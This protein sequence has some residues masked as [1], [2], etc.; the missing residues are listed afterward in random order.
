MATPAEV[1]QSEIPAEESSITREQRKALLDAF[2]QERDRTVE[3]HQQELDS[4]GAQHLQQRKEMMDSLDLRREAWGKENGKLPDRARESA[5]ALE[6][7]RQKEVLGKQHQAELE[8]VIANANIPSWQDY[9]KGKSRTGDVTAQA[10]LAEIAD[11]QAKGQGAG[12]EGP[13]MVDPTPLVLEGL[14]SKVEKDGSAVHYLRQNQEVFTDRGKRIE[15]LDSGDREIEAALRLA[16]AKF[17]EGTPLLL[18]G[19]EDFRERAARLAGEMGVPIRNRDLQELWQQGQEQG[20]LKPVSIEDPDIT[21]RNGL[22]GDSNAPQERIP[23]KE[24]GTAPSAD[25]S[26]K[27]MAPVLPESGEQINSAVTRGLDGTP[28]DHMR[29]PASEETRKMADRGGLP[30]DGEEILI[31]SDRYM[32]ARA[33]LAH[34]DAGT[35]LELL[36]ATLDGGFS[37]LAPEGKAAL[38]A[39][40]LADDRGQPTAKGAD[41]LLVQEQLLQEA[42]EKMPEV[43]RGQVLS[44]L[45]DR[46]KEAEEEN[47][48]QALRTRNVDEELVEEQERDS[49]SLEREVLEGME[50]AASMAMGSPIDWAADLGADAGPAN[51]P[52]QQYDDLPDWDVGH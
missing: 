8:T 51:A 44:P 25:P 20:R 7:A 50:M 24:A 2:R 49:G 16:S 4:L 40:G 17:R 33:E 12:L 29:I 28:G 52:E 39:A 11:L 27:K 42:R 47:R 13:E 35:R 6:V 45:Q 43:L 46:Q 41:L 34:A 18:T 22:V 31:P 21:P 5:W 30:V 10:L 19:D 1:L 15:V 26:D 37:S 38:L 23:V 32:A 48:Q 9:L 36:Q 3:S 14:S